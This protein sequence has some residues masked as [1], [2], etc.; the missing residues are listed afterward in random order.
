MRQMKTNTQNLKKKKNPLGCSTS[1]SK[2]ERYSNTGL[3]QEVRK[4]S[5]NL[6]PKGA[7][8]RTNKT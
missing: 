8:K 1:N 4:I 5:N 3:S 6:T 7:R 2:R